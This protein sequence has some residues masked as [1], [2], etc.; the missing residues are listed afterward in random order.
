MKEKLQSIINQKITGGDAMVIL[1]AAIVEYHQ[2]Q[3]ESLILGELIHRAEN[4][5]VY[6]KKGRLGHETY[7]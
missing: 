7:R 1:R 2:L 5:I 4:V 3:D 6:G